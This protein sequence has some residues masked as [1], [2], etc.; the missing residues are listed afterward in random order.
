[1]RSFIRI[2]SVVSLLVSCQKPVIYPSVAT[3]QI[4]EDCALKV[5]RIIHLVWH[6]F[7]KGSPQP[8]V[9]WQQLSNELHQRYP[10]WEIKYWNTENSRQFVSKNYPWFLETYD[11]Y[12]KPIKRADAIRYLLLEHYGGLYMDRGFKNLKPF[13]PLLRGAEFVAGQ[14]D[15]VSHSINNAWIASVPHHPLLQKVIHDLP[16]KSHGDV[17]S[18]T[19]PNMLTGQILDYLKHHPEDRTVKIYTDR[20]LY[21]FAWYDKD[22]PE[23]S[24]CR[25]HPDSCVRLYPEAYFAKFWGASWL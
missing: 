5:P 18:S 20:Y 19:G 13:E 25:E 4:C 3:D 11:N 6:Q 7:P 8:P 2:L 24:E 21:P 15:P 9:K 1:M 17:L 16:S 12:N 14:Q 22:K 10:E 23:P